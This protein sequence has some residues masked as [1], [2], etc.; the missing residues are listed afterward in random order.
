M[1]GGSAWPGSGHKC[2]ELRFADDPDGMP[3]ALHL[4]GFP[5]FA[6][7]RVTGKDRQIL[8]AD[9][10]MRGLLRHSW[11]HGHADTRGQFRRIGS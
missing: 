6:A 3:G 11:L 1:G 10:Q 2:F 4:L 5:V 9:N 7:L 8:I